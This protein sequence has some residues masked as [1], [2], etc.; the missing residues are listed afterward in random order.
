M[1]VMCPATDNYTNPAGRMHAANPLR[2]SCVPGNTMNLRLD[3]L[4][5]ELRTRGA[6]I[7]RAIAADPLLLKRQSGP[8]I[9]ANAG[10]MLFTPQHP[11]QL[12]AKGVVYRRE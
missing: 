11:H 8:F 2:G 1:S 5:E 10:P 7:L 6:E 4:L 9:L 12:F 3:H